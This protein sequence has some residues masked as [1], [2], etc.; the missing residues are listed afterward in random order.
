V[1]VVASTTGA[2]PT[3]IPT[4]VLVF[5]MAR[6]DRT[7]RA[8]DLYAVAEASGQSAE[9]VR[10]C[11][12]RLV[13][14]GLFT[15]DGEGRDA[16]FHLTDRGV[17]TWTGHLDRHRLGYVQD[18]AGRGWDRRWHLVGFA[19]PEARRDARDSLRDWLRQLGGA[20]VQG[21]L[22]VSAHPWED[23]VRAE[24]ERLDIG[25]YVTLVASDDLDVGGETDPRK[26]A[27]RLWDLDGVARRYQRFLADYADVPDALEAMRAR[28]ERL[29]D[30]EFLA[31][32]LAT[33]V[34]FQECV[35]R[36]PLLPPELLPRPWPGREARQLLARVRRLGVLAREH[37]DR[38]VLFHQFDEVLAEL[39]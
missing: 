8:D 14:E 36:D 22:F 12:R 31:G 33:F 3:G 13:A 28:H 35:H 20:P 4:R 24:A 17:S 16:V 7:I 38:P 29:T 26:L 21:G 15:R 18:L 30:A 25:G 27:Q 11:L 6:P 34:D 2:D 10:S 1:E 5:G 9:Q 37:H 39:V 32:A 19:V 23:E